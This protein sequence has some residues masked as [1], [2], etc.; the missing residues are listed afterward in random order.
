M[1]K[2]NKAARTQQLSY[3][4]RIMDTK[5]ATEFVSRIEKYREQE[6]AIWQE[7]RELPNYDMH[8]DKVIERVIAA[9]KQ[10]ASLLS[11]AESD[12]DSFD[13]VVDENG[14]LVPIQEQRG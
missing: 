5:T 12:L 2:P 10:A 3:R 4:R 6:A 7:M 9:R 1:G 14:D 13:W 11:D 8:D